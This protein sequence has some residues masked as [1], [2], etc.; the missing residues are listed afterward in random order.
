MPASMN[1]VFLGANLGL[2]IRRT[3]AVTES[4]WRIACMLRAGLVRSR[5]E[6]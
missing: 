4:L 3:H 1:G 6:V 5:G 2:L